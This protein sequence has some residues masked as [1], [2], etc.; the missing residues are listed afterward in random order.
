VKKIK[1]VATRSHILFRFVTNRVN[2]KS[3]KKSLFQAFLGFDDKSAQ[4]SESIAKARNRPVLGVHVVYARCLITTGAVAA[5]QRPLSR[6]SRSCCRQRGGWSISLRIQ[7]IFGVTLLWGVRR[8]KPC[9]GCYSNNH[10]HNSNRIWARTFLDASHHTHT[11]NHTH[12]S[13]GWRLVSACV[14]C[15]CVSFACCCCA[16]LD[17]IVTTDF[18]LHAHQDSLALS[19]NGLF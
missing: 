13:S 12:A 6:I 3:T 16:P 8:T 18:Q 4:K 11:S 15:A 7:P 9:Q 14:R 5:A 1:L 19:L 2:C 10:H 17:P